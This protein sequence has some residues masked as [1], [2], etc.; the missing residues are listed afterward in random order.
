MKIIFNGFRGFGYTD[1]AIQINDITILTG[2][3]SSVKSTFVK[4]LNVFISST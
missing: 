4:L 3:N 1:N 2:K